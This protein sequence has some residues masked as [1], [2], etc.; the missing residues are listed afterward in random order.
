MFYYVLLNIPLLF[1]VILSF[2]AELPYSQ[3]IIWL[4]AAE[5]LV[6][7]MSMAN[8]LTYDK[9]ARSSPLP[10]SQHHPPPPM[11]T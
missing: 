7:K 5:M 8:K 11:I 9:K 4:F 2:M 3:F 10:S 1:F 6:A